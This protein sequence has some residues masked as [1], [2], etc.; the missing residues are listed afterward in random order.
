[1][2]SYYYSNI[3]SHYALFLYTEYGTAALELTLIF[4]PRLTYT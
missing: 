1:M 3:L 4:S 2:L